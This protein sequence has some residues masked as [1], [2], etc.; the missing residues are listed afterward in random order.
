MGSR[1]QTLDGGVVSA[2]PCPLDFLFSICLL[3]GLYKGFKL[4]S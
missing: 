4:F 3:T 2:A 1:D